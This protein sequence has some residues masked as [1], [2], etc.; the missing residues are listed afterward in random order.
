MAWWGGQRAVYQQ[1]KMMI[2]TS[3]FLKRNFDILLAHSCFVELVSTPNQDIDYLY[4]FNFGGWEISRLPPNFRFYLL[5][6]QQITTTRRGAAQTFPYPNTQKSKQHFI[7]RFPLVG[8]RRE[9]L[10]QK[11]EK[12]LRLQTS[13]TD[14][15]DLFANSFHVW[16]FRE[17]AHIFGA[18]EAL[19]S[20]NRATSSLRISVLGFFYDVIKVCFK[21]TTGLFY[22]LCSC[23]TCQDVFAST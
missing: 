14:V 8:R 12:S 19:V 9:E 21:F 17:G 13:S 6:N 2:E 22:F 5:A 16:S 3:F 20:G 10:N 11:S 7:F 1:L 4:P 18:F 23:L 15:H